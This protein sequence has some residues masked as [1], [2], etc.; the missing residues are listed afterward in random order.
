[1]K[2]ERKIKVYQVVRPYRNKHGVIPKEERRTMTLCIGTIIMPKHHVENAEERIWEMFNWT[3]WRSSERGGE[4]LK[5]VRNGLRISGMRMFPNVNARGY[6][7]SDI[8]FLQNGR[9]MVAR[10]YGWETADSF[11]DAERMASD[12]CERF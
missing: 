4:W 2:N 9:W 5:A 11:K 1:M 7:N 12:Y 6:C 10:S 3:C 8:F